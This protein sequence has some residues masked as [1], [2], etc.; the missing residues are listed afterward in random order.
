MT[1]VPTPIPAEGVW[2]GDPADLPNW[3]AMPRRN[4]RR[5]RRGHYPIWLK[6]VS[7][8]LGLSVLVT[9][10]QIAYHAIRSDPR[11]ATVFATRQLRSSALRPDEKIV[12]SVDVWQRPPI[13]YFRAT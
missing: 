12:A 10:A 4:R 9:A 7:W 5:R 11:D 3:D 13:D 2:S 8:V 1:E 6:Y